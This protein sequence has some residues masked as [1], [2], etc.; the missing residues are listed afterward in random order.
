[1]KIIDSGWELTSVYPGQWMNYKME[2]YLIKINSCT[3]S[4]T[5]HGT[6]GWQASEVSAEVIFHGL[7]VFSLL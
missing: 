6:R 7:F 2:I 1:M 5:E 4:K 3:S